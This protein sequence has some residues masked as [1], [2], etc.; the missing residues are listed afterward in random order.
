ME[1]GTRTLFHLSTSTFSY[2]YQVCTYRF[3]D[4]GT[5]MADLKAS[6]VTFTPNGMA[7]F[8][9]KKTPL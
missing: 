1:L 3:F 9:T 5:C 8:Y 4:Y 2:M 6:K 7:D